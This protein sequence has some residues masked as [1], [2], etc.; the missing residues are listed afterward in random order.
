MDINQYRES[1][2][3]F[4][5]DDE[6]LNRLLGFKEE[7]DDTFLDMYLNM[8]LG[9]LNFIPPILEYFNYSNFPIPSLLIHQAAI[10]ALISNNIVNAR[11][12]L[13]YNN[14]GVTIKVADAGKYLNTIQLLYRSTDMEIRMYKDAK[15]AANIMGCFGGVM[16]PY[17]YLSGRS[18]TLNTNSLLSG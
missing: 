2:R 12:D 13:I 1:L 7:S 4:I 5:K 3:G 15:V 17:A 18:I 8:S 6:G 16:S 11:N 10:E 14:G 9:F